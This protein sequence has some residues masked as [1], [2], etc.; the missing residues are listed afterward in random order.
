MKEVLGQFPSAKI[1]SLKAKEVVAPPLSVEE[2][3]VAETFEPD[4]EEE[5]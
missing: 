1:V 3:D 4:M 5:D 2:A